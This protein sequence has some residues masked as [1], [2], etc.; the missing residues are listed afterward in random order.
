MRPCGTTGL[1]LIQAGT[2]ASLRSAGLFMRV[3]G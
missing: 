3:S 1:P 2:A